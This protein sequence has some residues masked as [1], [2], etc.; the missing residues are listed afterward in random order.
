MSVQALRNFW[1]G[2]VDPQISLPP[3]I[4]S[5][6][7]ISDSD[8]AK[9]PTFYD[10]SDELHSLL[11]EAVFVA[12]NVRFD[13]GFLKSEFK[14]TGRKFNPKLLC[15]VRLSRALYPAE[16]G[17]KLQNLIDRCGLQAASRHRA[18]DDA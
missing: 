4:T 7:G 5:L 3:F 15:T 16:R 17:H 12:H 8:L 13:Y 2:Q 1:Q 14:N 6:T 9:A 11:N 10:I 18:Y